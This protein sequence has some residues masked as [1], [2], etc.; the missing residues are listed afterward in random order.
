MRLLSKQSVLLLIVGLAHYAP[1]THAADEEEKEESTI[2][3]SSPSPRMGKRRASSPKSRKQTINFTKENKKIFSSK[4]YKKL[5]PDVTHD[6]LNAILSSKANSLPTKDGHRVVIDQKDNR[7]LFHSKTLCRPDELAPND[8]FQFFD[9]EKL[10]GKLRVVFWAYAV[11]SEKME[12]KHLFWIAH[13]LAPT[14]K[15]YH[16]KTKFR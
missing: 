14:S 16:M 12:K 7:Y 1:C 4:F 2:T 6:L 9:R 8:R 5:S 11:V 15:D 13:S 3:A 10:P